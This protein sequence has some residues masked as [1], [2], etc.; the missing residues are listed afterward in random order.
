MAWFG[1]VRGHFRSQ[2]IASFDR[3]PVFGALWGDAIGSSPR[4]LASEN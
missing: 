4:S 1:V 3:S 2:E